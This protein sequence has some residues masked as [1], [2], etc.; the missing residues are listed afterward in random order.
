MF[1]P[2]VKMGHSGHIS[3]CVPPNS[4]DHI[5]RVRTSF[6]VFLDSMESSLSQEYINMTVEG[7]WCQKTC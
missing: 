1:V 5:F 3:D 2:S 7:N 4:E 6:G